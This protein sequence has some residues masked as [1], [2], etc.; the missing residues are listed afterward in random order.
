METN[1]N[2]F[3]NRKI[4]VSPQIEMYAAAAYSLMEQSFGF[5]HDDGDNP[6][7]D[8]VEYKEFG[9]DETWDGVMW[10]SINN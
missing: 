8:V 1:K 9:F 7:D 4:Y 5:G 6:G 3:Q 10:E 2:K